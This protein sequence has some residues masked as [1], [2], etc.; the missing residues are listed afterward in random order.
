[1][2]MVMEVMF[3]MIVYNDG[4]LLGFVELI[5]DNVCCLL[6]FRINVSFCDQ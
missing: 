2:V 1:M 5:R 6:C 3:L 4:N